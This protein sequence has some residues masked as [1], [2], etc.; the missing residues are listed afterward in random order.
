VRG[1]GELA[2][3]EGHHPEVCFGWGHATVSL[4]T[5]KIKGL[6]ENDFILAAKINR[7]AGGGASPR[8]DQGPSPSA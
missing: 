2:E 5:R 8:A 4:Q 3:A 1:V 6:H 7:L